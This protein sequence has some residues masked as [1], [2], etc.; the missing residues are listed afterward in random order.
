MLATSR[1][2]LHVDGEHQI[3]VAPLTV[4]DASVLFV[5]RARAVQPHA[6]SGADREHI[7]TL[8]HH[9]DRL[10]LAIELAAARTKTL[11]VLEI[12]SRLDDRFRL[13]RQTSRG[14]PDR[15]DGL[16]AAIAWSYDMLFADERRTFRE[17]SVCPGGITVDLAERLCGPDALDLASRLVDRSLLVADTSGAA[18]RFTMLESLRAYGLARLEECSE[19]ESARAG[20]LSWC[21]ELAIT[22][23]RETRGPAQLVWLARLDQEHDNLRAA[24]GHAVAHDP[25]LAL[26]LVGELVLPWWFRGR[27]QEIREWVDAALAAAGTVRTPGRARVLA[28]SGLVAEPGPVIGGSAAAHRS[29]LALAEARGREALTIDEE[30]GDAEA[31]AYDCLLLMSTLTRQTSMGESPTPPDAA[32]LFARGQESFDRLGDDF[33]S[34]VIRIVD[35]MLAIADGDLARADARVEAASTFVDRLGERFS[36]SRL[37]YVR[38]MLEALA[39]SPRTAYGHIEHSL[40]LANELGI[41][42][43]VTAQARLLVHLAERSGEDGLAAQWRSFVEGRGAGWTHYDASVMAS[44]Y[45]RVGMRARA[46][47]QLA[48]AESAH[49]AALDWYRAAGLSEGVALSES[50]LGFLALDRHDE[51]S[52]TVHHRA[53]VDAAV[54]SRDDACVALALEG[55]AVLATRAGDSAR[56]AQ[57]LGAARTSRADTVASTATHRGDIDDVEER[58]QAELG[59]E[60]LARLMELG[61]RLE[62]RAV[63]AMA[64]S[65]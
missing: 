11:P 63:L 20:H 26:R 17:L 58:L 36:T 15:H 29:E 6:A 55:A 59:P 65:G 62:R 1:E 9:L 7:A 27:R 23:H 30:N 56:A 52:A 3:A 38:G 21:V 57:L 32:S 16:E 48:R 2:P 37:A 64:R 50:S 53:A 42:H 61:A 8:V 49:R 46:H 19:T 34:G 41:H 33:G 10:P 25:A 39:G 40:R 5:E 44:A 43:A 35:A 14:A 22:A 24:L 47:R 13:L 45:T 54:E 60:H 12:I 51:A 28:W 31:T 4:T 18:V